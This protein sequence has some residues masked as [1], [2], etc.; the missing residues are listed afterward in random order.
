[1]QKLVQKY[2][3]VTFLEAIQEGAEFPSSSWPLHVT[4]A[5]N[6]TIKCTVPELLEKLKVVAIQQKPIRITAGDDEFFGPQKQTRVT[7]LNMN[8]ELKVLHNKV[9]ALL[10]SVGAI[11]DEPA[12]IETGFRAHATVQRNARLQEGDTARIDKISLVD[13]FPGNDPYQRKVLKTIK[14]PGNKP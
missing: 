7:I 2:V 12:Y 8:E 13:M 11:F 3:L 14:F 6:F 1:M 5:S 10:K 4:I 9:V